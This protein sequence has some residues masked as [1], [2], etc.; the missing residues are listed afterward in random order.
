MEADL[1][2]YYGVDLLDYYRG[3]I[4][5]RKLHVLIDQ[6]PY[7]SATATS[8]NGG[9]PVWGPAEHLTA[10]LWS[11]IVAVNSPKDSPYVEQPRRAEMERLAHLRDKDSRAG[12]LKAVY[13]AKKR[14][15]GLE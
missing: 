7:D 2:R 6:L 12:D 3:L 8:Q 15:Y 1:Q 9:Y 14:Q 11:L 4:T 13:L 10:D 5:A